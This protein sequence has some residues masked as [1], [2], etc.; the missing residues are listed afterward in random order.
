[1]NL[2]KAKLALK[3]Y[4][5]YDQFRPLQADIIKSIFSGK[6]ALVLM[7]TGGGK[8]V[9]FQIPAVTLPG[10][11]IVVSPLIS[12]MKDQVEGLRANGIAAAFINSAIDS[13][14]QLRVEE[15]FYAGELDLLYVSPEK[16]VSGNFVS[17]LKRGKINLF[18]ID[19]AHCISAWGHDFRPEY[20]QMGMLKQHFPKVPV[21]ALT[22]TADKLTRKDIVDQL[23][24]E[25]P[26]IFIASFDRPNLSLEVRP[27]QQRLQQ[28]EDFVRKHPKQAGIIYTLSR[29]AAE[30]IAEKLKQKGFKA[31][32]Y[33]AGLSPDR[34]SKIQDHFINDNLL[35]ICAT[36]AFGMGID[37]SNVRW[38]I[39]YNLPKNLEGYYQ[40]I[41]RA[42][43]DG[44]KADTLLFYSFA[45]VSMLRDI[46]QNGENATQNEI[47]LVK[48]ERMQQY[49]ESLACRRR[50]LLAYFSE[51][52]S[53]N[54]GNC[55]I[56]RNPPQSI[57][58]TVIA[59]KA[60]SAV[61]RLNEQVPMGMLIDVLR[62]SGRR[63]IKQLGYDSI[64]TYGAGRDFSQWDWQHYI[65]QLIN[66]GYL[67]VAYD[68][69][70]VLRL[71]SASQEVLFKNR[72]VE[73]FKPTSY[74]ER[75][76]EEKASS[77]IKVPTQLK[78]ER[79]RDELFE[80]LRQIR[81]EIAQKEGIPPYLIFSD[82]TLEEMAFHKPQT[83]DDMLAVS[84]V[85][86]KKLVQ[87]GYRF[88]KAIRNYEKN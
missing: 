78:K 77:K 39:H 45:D 33:H 25:E 66:L 35:I 43:R 16:L 62:G 81:K 10:T 7:P 8:S 1:M 41:G 27:G 29:K 63:E 36:V 53:E 71:T 6:D 38:V 2:D 3:R 70:N 9:C 15:S 64:K 24:L 55:D 28:I 22:A 4:F 87:F 48:L 44:A 46:I 47:Q 69:A 32:A 11:C 49:A 60:L 73:L 75:Q 42:G 17:I 84:G 79:L 57:D 31:E 37:K 54:C 26:G 50:I 58:G 86:E 23:K 21:V 85:G 13:R 56:C 82:A 68:A 80:Y 12:L 20:T 51:N 18:A 59:Q 19:E 40:E 67:E 65:M 76:E 83:E 88:I 30:D 52:L 74:K 72:S 5:G 34:R 14:E 61:Y